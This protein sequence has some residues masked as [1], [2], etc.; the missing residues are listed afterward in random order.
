MPPEA[1]NG[2]LR[3][4]LSELTRHHDGCTDAELLSDGFTIGQQSG[5][6]IDGAPQDRSET[7]QRQRLRK[8]R[9]LAADHRGGA[10]GNLGLKKP[11]RRDG[12]AG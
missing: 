8:V 12:A 3:R 7:H 4:A 9:G 5:L 2:E 1:L 11:H 10:E 6:P